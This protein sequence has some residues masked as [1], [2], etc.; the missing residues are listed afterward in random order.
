MEMMV[1]KCT[2]RLVP[3][4]GEIIA[5]R[6]HQEL[7]KL[8]SIKIMQIDLKRPLTC[9]ICAQ[10]KSRTIGYEKCPKCTKRRT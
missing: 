4:I 1:E 5:K 6:W 8:G 7:S 10:R 9:V 2:E 3:Q